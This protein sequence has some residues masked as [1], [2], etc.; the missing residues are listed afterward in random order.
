LIADAKTN[1]N[2][3]S[4]QG[5]NSLNKD[6]EDTPARSRLFV[7]CSKEIREHDLFSIFQVFGHLDYCKLMKDKYTGESKGCAYVKFSKASTAA[8]AMETINEQQRDENGFNKEFF[9]V[10]FFKL[11]SNSKC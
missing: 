6:P 9:K 10:L 3:S 1:K 5:N 11:I 8:N 7:I 4:P 2:K